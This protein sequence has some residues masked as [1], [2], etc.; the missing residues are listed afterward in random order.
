ME[1]DT[2][3]MLRQRHPA[4]RLL[5]AQNATLVLSFLGTYFVEG[6]RGA[7]A[8]QVLIGALDE[9]LHLLNAG[10]D[11]PPFPR[12]PK[13]YLDGWA[14]PEAGWL[15]RFYPHSS[16]D[17]H[18]DATPAF[19]KAYGW[20][21]TLRARPFVGTES[22]LH[23][24]VELL[25]QI[26][27]GTETDVESRL[28]HLREQRAQL[29][30]AIR[31]AERGNFTVLTDVAVRDRYQQFAGTARELL[32]DF[33]EVE[34]NFRRLDRDARERI[35]AWNG[36]K[37]ELLADLVA[38]RADISSSDQGTSFQ[39][40]FDFLLSESRQDE[41]SDL[42]SRVQQLVPG[43]ADARLRTI[44]HDWSEAAERTQ[45]TVRQI[46]EQVRRFLDDQVWLENRRVLDI[47]RVVESGALACRDE[48]PELGLDVDLPGLPFA[49]PFERPLYSAQPAARVDSMLAPADEEDIDVSA[50]FTQAFVDQARL[51]QNIRSLLPPRTSATLDE[52]IDLCPVEQGAAEIIGYVSL[53]AEDLVVTLDDT[54]ETV[55]A[56]RDPDGTTR[57]ARLPK[58]IVSRS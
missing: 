47:V 11:E 43:D 24:V 14:A 13:E 27:H 49:L 30:H 54:E 33:R 21:T 32:S 29:D 56:Y 51:A 55:V 5:R 19:E 48:P 17:V 1:F 57:R 2:V 23:T 36:P 38:S 34:D 42:V 37:G 26:V 16:D 35:A 4:W 15:R 45:Q 22:R 10:A 25:R 20:V 9:H 44:H 3:E 8:E 52:I 46:S 40:F 18:Y 7:T 28:A 12:S 50:L 53:N 39:A 6:N 58:V 41:L 31:E